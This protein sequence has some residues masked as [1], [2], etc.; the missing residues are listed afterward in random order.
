MKT[1]ELTSFPD[2]ASLAQFVAQR[3]L[4]EVRNA[5]ARGNAFFVALSGGRIA[6]TLF[7]S[8]AKMA[9]ELSIS[10][11]QVHFFWA[12]ERCVPPTDPESNFALAWQTLLLP[13]GVPL[14][15]IHRIAG[16]EPPDTAAANA[17]NEIK[18]VISHKARGLPVLDLVLLGMGEDGHVASLF[19]GDLTD[20]IAQPLIYRPVIG[21]KPPPHRITISYDMIAAGR[22]VW[23]LA[24]GIGK[25]ETLK[26]SLG[27]TGTTPLAQVLRM[28]RNT[29]LYTDLKFQ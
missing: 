4:T 5:S 7:L 14:A 13:L 9:L 15:R 22:Q 1:F 28:R 17:E 6:K 12:D 8:V 20:T 3:W 26:N 29:F 21:P 23:V 27:E 25:E 19:P 16:E 11:E 2:A 24:S 10:F 18:N